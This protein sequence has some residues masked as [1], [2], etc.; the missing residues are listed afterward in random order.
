MKIYL[1]N[2]CYNRPFDDHTHSRV[3]RESDAVLA[4]LARAKDGL[5]EIIGSA[6]IEF[7]I[8][9]CPR[10]ER[11]LWLQN[12]YEVSKTRLPFSST[13]YQRAN[14]LMSRSHLR[15]L[16][17]MH[18]AYAESAE[19]N[20]LLTTDDQLAREGVKLSM[21]VKVANP[22]T[23]IAEVTNANDGGNP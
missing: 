12:L 20:Y 23:Y 6:A 14:E 13:V 16:D 4:V 2:C 8:S 11:R 15:L 10:R 22:L 5:D 21:T 19:A 7:E 1:D 9:R 3:A 17:S 18:L